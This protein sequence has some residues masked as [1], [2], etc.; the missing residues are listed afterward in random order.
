MKLDNA[1]AT[2]A[3]ATLAHVGAEPGVIKAPHRAVLETETR[4]AERVGETSPRLQEDDELSLLVMLHFM[5][6][7]NVYLEL[8]VR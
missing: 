8:K 5:T 7:S 3:G 6:L 4:E 2:P 1:S